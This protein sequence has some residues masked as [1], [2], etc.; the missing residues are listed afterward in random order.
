[1]FFQVKGG[2]IYDA[3]RLSQPRYQLLVGN[4]DLRYAPDSTKLQREL[5]WKRQHRIE[6][7]IADVVAWYR[8]HEDWWKKIKTTNAYQEYYEK[9]ANAEWD[10]PSRE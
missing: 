1:M 9:Q 7:S 5:G 8:S 2:D 4:A 3:V 6:E 10:A